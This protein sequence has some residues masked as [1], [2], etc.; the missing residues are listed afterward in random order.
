MLANTCKHAQVTQGTHV[1]VYSLCM[2]MNKL[3]AAGSFSKNIA[4]NV[5]V[6]TTSYLPM[7]VHT[8]I[9]QPY[10]TKLKQLK[11]FLY[12]SQQSVY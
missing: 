2:H 11:Y 1:L 9:M 8:Y 5:A 4:F 3:I 10:K 12:T 7:S 6:H